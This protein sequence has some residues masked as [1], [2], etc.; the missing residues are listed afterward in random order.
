MD[1]SPRFLIGQPV[2]CRWAG[3]QTGIWAKEQTGT[4]AHGP[5]GRGCITPWTREGQRRRIRNDMEQA[6]ETHRGSV[7][8]AHLHSRLVEDLHATLETHHLSHRTHFHVRNFHEL[9]QRRTFQCGRCSVACQ[10][11]PG[12]PLPFPVPCPPPGP[13]PTP[14]TFVSWWAKT[15]R[16]A[17]TPSDADGYPSPPSVFFCVGTALKDRLV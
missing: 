14:G 9:Q 3:V 10:A 13:C 16:T 5:T 11:A 1:C 4:W 8:C 7:R 17:R 6:V 15:S 2:L 12:P